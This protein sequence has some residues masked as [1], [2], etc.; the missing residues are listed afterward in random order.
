MNRRF[1]AFALMI[2]FLAPL[3]AET[4]TDTHEPVPYEKNEFPDWI[5]DLRRAEIITFGSLPFIT[6]SASIYYD[7]YRYYDHDK[8]SGYEPWPFK[9]S[10]TAVALSE[11]EQKRLVV[12]SACISVG[13]AVFDYGFRAVRRAIR[14]KRAEREHQLIVDPITIEPLESDSADAKPEPDTVKSPSPVGNP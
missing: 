10:D 2:A 11:D 5:K 8:E 4:T 1:A 14:N 3:G 7:I 12:I 9:K 6:F 13:V